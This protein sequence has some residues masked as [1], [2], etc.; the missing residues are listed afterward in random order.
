MADFADDAQAISEQALEHA[1]AERS[2]KTEAHPVSTGYCL[3][4]HC[5]EEL[6]GGRLFCGPECAKEHQRLSRNT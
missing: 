4:F 1:L 3:N 5:A 2:S 6:D